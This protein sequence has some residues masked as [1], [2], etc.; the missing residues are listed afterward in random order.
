MTLGS[1]TWPFASYSWA[2]P[3]LAG[4]SS[5]SPHIHSF[6]VL[7]RWCVFQCAPRNEIL[8]LPNYQK[9][10]WPSVQAQLVETLCSP[11]P[12]LIFSCDVC[13]ACVWRTQTARCKLLFPLGEATRPETEGRAF[14]ASS[15]VSTILLL[16]AAQWQEP[17]LPRVQ[18]E[19]TC[20][21]IQ[22]RV[23]QTTTVEAMP[24]LVPSSLTGET[25]LDLHLGYPV[26]PY[27]VR[28]GLEWCHD[29]S[30]S[31]EPLNHPP[32]GSPVHITHFCFNLKS[33]HVVL[34]LP[35]EIPVSTREAS[36]WK[37]LQQQAKT[38]HELLHNPKLSGTE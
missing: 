25:F 28:K 10:L 16:A 8:W 9:R 12:V 29:R 30:T 26:V 5:Q 19:L 7:L 1:V 36:N 21:N 24:L 6:L 31:C 17:C 4:G 27:N 18:G 32:S 23:V 37:N 34:N 3:L 13:V 33:I 38:H 22:R 20:H 2:C 11:S 35:G 15:S 14:P